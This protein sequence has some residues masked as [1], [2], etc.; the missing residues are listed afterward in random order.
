MHEAV[1]YD[2]LFL[3]TRAGMS[4]VIY[5]LVYYVFMYTSL[6][7]K[8][9]I[10]LMC[11][12]LNEIRA[13]VVFIDMNLHVLG[14]YPI[15]TIDTTPSQDNNSRHVEEATALVVWF[16]YTHHKYHMHIMYMYK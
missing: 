1:C 2:N 9:T 13:I 15:I 8:Q 12:L 14:Q 10:S 6:F 11:T 3:C 5:V 7:D 4:R 16:M